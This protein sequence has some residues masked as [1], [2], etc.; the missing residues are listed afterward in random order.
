MWRQTDAWERRVAQK[1]RRQWIIPLDATYHGTVSECMENLILMSRR[2]DPRRRSTRQ[3]AFLMG[4]ILTDR[5][6]RIPLPRR[7][8]Y[9]KEYCKKHGRRY[10]TLNDL[11]AWMLKEITVPEDVDVTVTVVF[12][13]AFDADKIHRVC[14]GRGFR[15]VF[16]IDP[17]RVLASYKENPEVQLLPGQSADWRAYHVPEAPS[18]KQGKKVPLRW[19]GKVLACTDA[20]ATARQV[21]E[22]YEVRWQVELFFREL[23]SRL[24]FGCYVLMK[25]EAVERYV[26]FL[27]MGFQQ[28]PGSWRFWAVRW[29]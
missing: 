15:E 12:D 20:T 24:Q 1:K 11:A 13:S 27:L 16:P 26:D 28:L 5:G 9:T 10:R 22:C 21:I 18:H 2:Q 29:R 6:G 17:N 7:S 25:F 23:K 3:H 8:Y 4:M 19:H 14:R